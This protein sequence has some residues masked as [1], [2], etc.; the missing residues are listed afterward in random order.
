MDTIWFQSRIK[1]LG[2]S[3]RALAQVLGIDPAQVTNLL[4]GRRR[5][6]LP[7]AAAVAAFL[8]VSVED[9]LKHAG[10]A[11]SGGA[12]RVKL[13]GYVDEHGE[14]HLSDRPEGEVDAPALSPEG[15]IAVRMRGDQLLMRN[16]V[17]FFAPGVGVNPDAI[18]RLSVVRVGGGP[19]LVRTISPGLEPG[20]YDLAGPAGDI[21]EAK[22]S[23]ASPVLWIRP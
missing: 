9:V 3:Q 2:K 16:G 10:L 23:A 7:E 8:N 17:L 21:V 14:I 20:R 18:G 4:K 6:Q 22:L 1:N 5:M 12:R 11:V 13:A 19:W 15:T